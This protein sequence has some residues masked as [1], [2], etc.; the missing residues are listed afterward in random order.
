MA[1]RKPED[2]DRADAVIVA[3]LATGA[4]RA[5]AAKAAGVSE[6]TVYERL[7]DPGIRARVDAARTDLIQ[8]AAGQ[9][10]ALVTTALDALGELLAS[11]NDAVRLGAVKAALDY[12]LRLRESADLEARMVA[13]EAAAAE[14]DKARGVP[15]WRAA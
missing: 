2:M 10:L 15:T 14:Q 8:Q 9:G 7:R 6:S 13:L 12:A 1:R 4:T 5:K 3:A 11:T